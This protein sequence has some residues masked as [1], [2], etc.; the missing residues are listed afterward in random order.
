MVV[1]YGK[2]FKVCILENVPLRSQSNSGPG[3]QPN[4]L[5]NRHSNTILFNR[6]SFQRMIVK[7]AK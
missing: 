2:D 4:R 6:L 3:L 1:L 5:V 7:G